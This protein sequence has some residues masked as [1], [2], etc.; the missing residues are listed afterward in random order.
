MAIT[1]DDLKYFKSDHGAQSDNNTRS[2]FVAS[3]GGFVSVEELTPNL[4]DLFDSVP[5]TEA[6]SGRVEYRCIYLGNEHSVLT[7]WDPE[8]WIESNT[9]SSLTRL[10]IAFDDIQDP[11]VASAAEELDNEQDL[12]DA[13]NGEIGDKLA[14]LVWSL[15]DGEGNA[16]PFPV[17][18]TANDNH[19]RAN[20]S[21]ALWIRRTIDAGAPAATET[22][23]LAFRGD[24]DA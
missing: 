3:L 12:T 2:Q 16:I 7:L 18:P 8:V 9:A 14:G 6:A 11:N 17:S 15:A 22:A 19:L 13:G 4:H 23:T 24:T 20:Q 1:A 21:K 5:S 10:E